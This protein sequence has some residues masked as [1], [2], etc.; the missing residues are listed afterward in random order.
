[1]DTTAE[2]EMGMLLLS[3][4]AVILA[5]LLVPRFRVHLRHRWRRRQA[6][7]MSRALR[8]RDRLQPPSLIYARLR[9]MDALAFEELL[10]ESFEALGHRVVRN[11]RYTGDG[12]TD[13]Q[14]I[15]AGEVWLI[16]AKRYAGSI[17]PEHVQAF[18]A[19]CRRRGRR[20][21]L[22][23]TGRT[24]PCS[25]AHIAESG[26]ISVISGQALIGLITGGPFSP[27]GGGS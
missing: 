6:R 14:V 16:Q 27:P 11:A 15:I 2:M 19:L 20:G 22:I 18:A 12:G 1:M 3:A 9:A 7:A 4:I 23:H 17:R 24:G 25:R 5:L 10:L 13:G 8:G 26:Y 21:L